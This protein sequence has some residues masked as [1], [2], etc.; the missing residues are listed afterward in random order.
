MDKKI[1]I[2]GSFG[3]VINFAMQQNRIP[4]IRRLLIENISD[5]IL[6]DLTVTVTSDPEFAEELKINISAVEPGQTLDLKA[7]AKLSASYLFSI[8]ERVE[9]TLRITV[10]QGENILDEETYNI[11][12]LAYDEWSGAGIMPEIIA[13]F[14]TPNHPYVAQIVK[15]AGALL[16]KWDNDPSF[17]GYQRQNPNAVRR[18]MAAIYGALQQENIA[19]CVPPASF[20]QA[21]QRIRLCD[22]IQTQK[23]GTCIDLTLLFASCLEFAGLNPIIVFFKNH[24]FVGC[25]LE[26]ESF[27]E[28]VQDDPSMLTK[29]AAQGINEICLAETT[30]FA[31]DKNVSFEEA[32]MTADKELADSDNFTYFVDIR[33]CRS[34]QIRPLPSAKNNL[35]CGGDVLENNVKVTDAPGE[36]QSFSGIEQTGS[37]EMSKQQIWER[38][39]LDLSLRNTLLSFRVTKN[40]VQLMADTLSAL[41]DALSS[42]EEFQI[43]QCPADF[44]EGL[45]DNKIY[46][47]DAS[48]SAELLKTEF[49]NRRIRT[50]LDEK[51]LETA[52]K[53]LYRSAKNSLE[54]NGANTLYL[55]L[56]FLRWYETDISEKARYA[57]LVMIPVDIVRKSAQKGYVIRIRDEEPQFNITL[58][59]WLRTEFGITISGLDPLPADD[60]GVDLNLVFNTVRRAVMDKSRWDVEE[61]AFIGLFSFS[62]FI[63]WNDIR[64][65]VDDLK[66]NKVVASLMSGVMEW[67]Q[68]NSF[69]QPDR[70][71]DILKPADMAVPVSA[72]SSQMA[73]ICAAGKGNTFVLHGP[74]GTGKSQTITNMIAN[75]L[76]QGKSIL[77]IAE[78]MAALSVVQRRL[79]NIGLAPFCLEVHSNKA[80][81]K[82]VLEQLDRTLNIGR[83]KSPES[84]SQ[85]AER[86]Y[87]LRTKLNDSIK[88]IHKK[89]PWG[90]S[91]Y[92]DILKAEQYKD[93]PDCISFTSQQIAELTPE[94][95]SEWVDICGELSAAAKNCGGVKEHPLREIAN[96]A[97]T[98]MLK[99]DISEELTALMESA[100]KLSTSSDTFAKEIGAGDVAGYNQ[101][102]ALSE[103]SGLLSEI[104]QL[105]ADMLD[106]GELTGA[107]EKLNTVCAAGK[108][109]DELE[110][111]LLKSFAPPVLE[112]DSQALEL[113]WQQAQNSWIL[114]KAMTQG[115][116][117][118]TLKALSRDPKGFDKENTPKILAKVGEYQ[119]NKKTVD[120]SSVYFGGMFGILWNNGKCDWNNIQN[121]YEQA[122]RIRKCSYAA[123]GESA[124]TVLVRIKEIF[125]EG[126]DVYRS[127]RIQLLIEVRDSFENVEKYEASL[128]EKTGFDFSSLHNEAWLASLKETASRLNS[129]ID[130]LRDWCSYLAVRRNA[131]TAGIGCVTDALEKGLITEQNILPAFYRNISTACAV[132]AMS[133]D[134][135]L[136]S[137]NGAVY[138]QEIQKYKDTC[139]SFENLTRQELAARLSANIP[140][141]SE[142]VAGSSEIGI[143]QRAI[144][145]GGR[146]MSIRK[147][148]DSI[149]NLLRKLC[150]CML[151]SPISVAQYIDPKYPKFDLVIFDEAS[152][153]PTCEAVGAIARGKELVVV[154]DPKQ[155]PPTSFFASNQIDEDNFEK[156]DLESVLDDCLALSMPQE[157]LLW[158]YRSRHESLIAFSNREYYD[159]KL[160]TFPSPNDMISEVKH[161][162][163]EG[164][165]DRGKTKQNK[166]EAEAIVKEIVRR[167][168][169]SELKKMSMGVVTFSVVQQHLIEDMLEEEFRNHPEL[170]E[171]NSAS[172]EPLFVK[173]LENVQGDE[174]DV[175]MFSIGYGPDADGKVALNFGPLNRDGGWRRLNV[176]VSRAR[177]QMLVF[178]VLRPEQI[179]LSKTRSD[180]L[181][182]LKAFLEFAMR[183]KSALTVKTTDARQDHGIEEIIAE[184]LR[185]E[186]IEA[187]TNIG[188]SE[189]KIDI[190]IVDPRNP[191]EY[192]LGILCD[193]EKYSRSGTA[194]DRNILQESVLKSL[195][196]NIHRVWTL[197]W[198]E[199]PSKE[200]ARI[201]TAI[202]NAES[203]KDT[204]SEPQP[205][206]EP[207]RIESFERVENP[208]NSQPLPVYEIC[209][210]NIDEKYQGST[211]EFLRPESRAK[212]K[213]QTAAILNKEA[214]ISKKLLYKRL[215]ETWGISRRSPKTDAAFEEIIGSLEII[216]TKNE[217]NEFYWKAGQNPAEYCEFRIPSE[218]ENTKRSIEDIACEEVSA[219]VRHVLKTQL[220]LDEDGLVHAVASLLGIPRCT[221]NVRNAILRGINTA[222][223]RGYAEAENGRISYKD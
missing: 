119:S 87:G 192:I 21:G 134:T 142:G 216:V 78:K 184:T 22:S 188:C 55:A 163:V 73:A 106:N 49:Q 165:Y 171:L 47:I 90:T 31:A 14:V 57:P 122:V 197:D 150:P 112:L 29:R 46:R 147:L 111:E 130:G 209:S 214:P 26:N 51:A 199:N 38:K 120:E 208:Q 169:D 81:K 94:K 80:K 13:A 71:D 194:R 107:G 101:A 156:E 24:A 36:I 61:L 185:K 62:Q 173:N 170:D 162:P 97:Y 222:I 83:I 35:L 63:M 74:P 155:L 70:L 58:L 125:A 82:E 96:P 139:A 190:G 157:H 115:K 32:V 201:R 168:Q 118:K 183:G 131:V 5:E 109:R 77:F 85:Q 19:Y 138:E 135:E 206:P 44:S 3:Q 136:S 128:S 198:W 154:G 193:G 186:G 220:S 202:E 54:E 17:T 196:W 221:E 144:K 200:L 121:V 167:L 18:Q 66:Q 108:R 7:D 179:D 25:W 223:R 159:N 75:A 88:S 12:V 187:H 20:E 152:Q 114:A 8:T 104:G 204:Q 143:L 176:A 53:G 100:D 40:S 99:N 50:F 52:V 102:Q 217:S 11:S 117:V 181:A 215:L 129:N 1:Q 110:A 67:T 211:D 133:E 9:G 2:S 189:Y 175:I 92:D 182:G 45:G 76:Y 28:C 180:G 103:L 212:L 16:Q 145:S 41:E 218:A 174:R 113:E 105:P 195:G 126:I 39:L 56:G 161:I 59:E 148:F 98:Q 68:E 219:A 15:N 79:E 30:C 27:S 137:F 172:Q 4:V 207:V 33:R 166:A 10:S 203:G 91:V 34:S 42:G 89:R 191:G 177:R 48:A 95:Y 65:R 64:N 140:V 158:H 72:D 69:P 123:A 86:L 141:L 151:M 149:P 164:F 127:R 60:S 146:G 43:M 205:Q 124:G 23:M 178:S 213:K 37:A 116:V 6:N 153:L 132:T 93:Y 210:L 84:Y 160:Y